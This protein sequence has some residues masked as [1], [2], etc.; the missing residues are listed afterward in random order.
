MHICIGAILKPAEKLLDL[1][2][3]QHG[4]SQRSRYPTTE[5]LEFGTL[6]GPAVCELSGVC[7]YKIKPLPLTYLLHHH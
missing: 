5:T 7:R 6:F 1:S 2:V 3:I 4:P